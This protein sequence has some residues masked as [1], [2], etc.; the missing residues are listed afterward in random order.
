MRVDRK[1]RRAELLGIIHF[2]LEGSQERRLQ[3]CKG[4]AR[5]LKIHGTQVTLCCA[6]NVCCKHRDKPWFSG[7]PAAAEHGQNE[8]KKQMYGKNRA[9]EHDATETDDQNQPA[10]VFTARATRQ[11]VQLSVHQPPASQ[12]T[13]TSLRP[14]PLSLTV[15]CEPTPQI[16][17]AIQER[18][19]GTCWSRFSSRNA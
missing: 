13:L 10:R 6:H 15:A 19:V 5:C 9:S 11:S 17:P 3:W 2:L 12:L 14:Q 8:Q 1:R 16:T 7:H 18:F 4:T